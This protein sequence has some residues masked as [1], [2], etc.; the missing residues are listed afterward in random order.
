M[1]NPS[2]ETHLP[3]ALRTRPRDPRGYPVPHSAWQ[4][5]ATG[6]YDF[7]ILD[8]TIRLAD[9][10]ERLCAISGEPMP[11]GEYWFIGGPSSFEQRVFV[12]GPMLQEVAEYSLQVCP[13]LALL[14]SQYRGVGIPDDVRLEGPSR[15]K[16]EILMLGRT[17]SYEIV[18][19]EGFP[20]VRAAPWNA[21][22][23]WSGGERLD[24]QSALALLA[25]VAPEI[26]ISQGGRLK[27]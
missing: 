3:D 5:P 27:R 21:V 17:R 6:E 2:T 11:E 25:K 9:L 22:N 16:S 12:D 26:D 8:Q 23:W 1:P 7:R 19:I 20:Y 13:H 24:K 4:D 10:E 15:E 18:E 14:A